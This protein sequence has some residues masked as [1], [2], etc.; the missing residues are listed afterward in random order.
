[1]AEGA[2]NN[3]KETNLHGNYNIGAS[4]WRN[5]SIS[6]QSESCCLESL[7]LCYTD[8]TDD[9]A[10]ILARGL[11]GN[12][13]LKRLHLRHHEEED[14]PSI[15][16]VGLSTFV[17]V[18]C[19]TSSINNTYLSNHTIEALWDEEYGWWDYFLYEIEGYEDVCRDLDLYLELN[20]KC[21]QFAAR[22][23]ILMHH[24][25]LDM[26]PLLQWELKCLPLA[27]SWFERAKP[28][29]TLSMEEDDASSIEEDGDSSIEEDDDLEQR[30]RLVDESAEVF[31]SRVLTAIYEFVRGVPKRV[32]ERR[33]E[34]I[35][36][37]AYDEKIARLLNDVQQIKRKISQ[38]NKENKR[39]R[40]I[41][42]HPSRDALDD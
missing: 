18:L 27:V 39:L 24:K 35:L 32:L 40:R 16:P 36:V 23:K 11:V 5:L 33:G 21:P 28:C 4:G 30:R 7:I 42:V 12:K 19:D 6:L 38:L 26:K 25:Y 31:E 29:I 37:A 41:V 17:K 1:M 9:S 34:L 13:L 3:C 10:E 20:R 8:I 22:R 14:I 15:T 2:A